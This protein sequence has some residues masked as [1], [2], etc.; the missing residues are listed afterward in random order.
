MLEPNRRT[1]YATTSERQAREFARVKLNE[2]LARSPKVRQFLLN[3]ASYDVKDS[4]FDKN[5]ANGSG[6]TISYMKDNADRTRGYSAD[7]LMLDEIQDMDPNEIPVVLEILSASLNPRKL[8]AGTPK[9]IDNPIEVMWQRSTQHEIFF[10]C[11]GCNAWNDIGYKNVG[12]K[13]P[14]CAKCG[15]PLD[16]SNFV[17]LPTTQEPD[18]AIYLGVRVPQPALKLHWGFE[19]K[20][21][22]ILIKKEE[23]DEAKFNNEVL[24]IS[25]SKGQRFIT[26]EDILMCCTD[27]DFVF[28]PTEDKMRMF[29]NVAMGIDWS[30]GGIDFSSKTVLAVYADLR[31][32]PNTADTQLQLLYYHVFPQQDPMKT[33]REIKKCCRCFHSCQVGFLNFKLLS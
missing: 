15:K 12:L 1:F 33:I 22:D 29:G 3:K 5:F 20:W 19:K 16:M 6:I 21:K 13:G 2:F 23:Y 4:L 30:G 10:K 28:P 26:E 9:T 18:K 11:T 24:G 17:I 25:F 8:F 7:N 27:A 31:I 32:G 14:I